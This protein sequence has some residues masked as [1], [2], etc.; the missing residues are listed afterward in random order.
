MPAV[1]RSPPP[2]P[3]WAPPLGPTSSHQARAGTR[4]KLVVLRARFHGSSKKT[5]HVLP[6]STL[7]THCLHSIIRMQ[8]AYMPLCLGEGQILQC[9]SMSQQATRGPSAS[10]WSSLAASMFGQ[11]QG[12]GLASQTYDFRLHFWDRFLGSFLE[13]LGPTGSHHVPKLGPTTRFGPHRSD[14]L[15]LTKHAPGHVQSWW[16]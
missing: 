8:S 15:V 11:L 14:P 1:A 4:A 5:A 16:F 9:R 10:F 6:A 7:W 13:G 3:I 12:T 2:N